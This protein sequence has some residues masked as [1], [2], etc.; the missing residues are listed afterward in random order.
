MAPK[1]AING[2]GRIGRNV[3]RAAIERNL[4]LDFVAINDITDSA[5]LAHLLE[6]DSVYGRLAAQISHQEDSIS[7]DGKRIRV[8]AER[9]PSQIPW[10]EVGA[11]IV[12]ESTGLFT[13][14]E[15]ASRH[16]RGSVQKVI[17]SAPAKDPDITVALGVNADQ[18]DPKNHHIVSNA[19]CTT[20]CLAPVAKTLHDVFGIR[21]GLMTT[22]HS[23]TTDQRILDLP[24]KDLRRARS[25]GLSMIPTTTGAAVAVTLVLPELQG[26]LD[27]ISI[28]VPTP[29][30][31]VVDLTAELERNAT[32]DEV[33]K[34]FQAVAQGNLK[35]ILEYTDEPLVSI[36]FKK[37][38]HSSIVDGPFTKVLGKNLVKV[39]AWYDNEWGYS[40][41]VLELA[42]FVA[43]SLD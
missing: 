35:G 27:G 32:E 36:D 38:P 3:L 9:D 18:Y 14:R 39:L 5:T 21:K 17:I 20:N 10:S 8:F 19:S 26:R 12:V 34:R 11:R 31:S 15:A 22:V 37:N 43:Q 23:Y 33:R 40:N 42:D 28:R 30:V 1:V 41:R 24:H 29:C 25:A 4:N 7:I 2:F 13:K 6:Y 16:L